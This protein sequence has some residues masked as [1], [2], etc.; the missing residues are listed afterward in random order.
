MSVHAIRDSVIPIGE[1]DPD[2]VSWLETL[3]DDAKRGEV[4]AIAFVAL[5]EPG[6]MKLWFKSNGFLSNS[7]VGACRR[8][9]S[10]LV[11]EIEQ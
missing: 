5:K 1:P 2:I 4:R 7:L 6:I 10:K 9:E 3:L 11:S 8:L